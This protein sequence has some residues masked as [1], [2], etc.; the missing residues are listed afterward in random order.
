MLFSSRLSRREQEASFR[1]RDPWV[2]F[3][4]RRTAYQKYTEREDAAFSVVQ[5][6]NQTRPLS[7]IELRRS[8]SSSHV[9]YSRAPS[10]LTV[11]FAL[12]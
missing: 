3:R 2:T 5:G 10:C 7:W 9:G 1:A 4:S 6:A 12:G 8:C 11:I